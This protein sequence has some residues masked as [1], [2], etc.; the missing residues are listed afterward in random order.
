MPTYKLNVDGVVR[1][2]V[3]EKDE[4]LLYVLTDALKLKG[5]R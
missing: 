1:D 3:A 4:P 5:P 2:V